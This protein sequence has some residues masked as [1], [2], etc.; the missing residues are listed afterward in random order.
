M[1][2][3]VLDSVLPAERAMTLR[4]LRFVGYRGDT[5]TAGFFA[6]RESTGSTTSRLRWGPV[7]G[8]PE[9]PD[10]R[11]E[12]LARFRE[13]EFMGDSTRAAVAFQI[14]SCTGRCRPESLAWLSRDER[15]AW[16]LDSLTYLQRHR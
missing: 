15:Q 14:V 12:L 2:V 10:L 5:A 3:A 11:G 7:F 6:I 16:R 9:D 1:Y 13:V 8:L 4:P